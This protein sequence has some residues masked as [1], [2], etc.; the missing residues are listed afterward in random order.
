[1]AESDPTVYLARAAARAGSRPGDVQARQ[2]VWYQEKRPG[3][4]LEHAW[5][6]WLTHAQG[7]ERPDETQAHPGA[8][9]QDGGQQAVE[10]RRRPPTA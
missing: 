2:T 4:P 8:E 3:T 1:M 5:G 6:W 9:A 10:N 7:I